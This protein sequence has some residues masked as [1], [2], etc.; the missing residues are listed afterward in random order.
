MLC[1]VK[2]RLATQDKHTKSI[3]NLYINQLK[4]CYEQME[5]EKQESLKVIYL[6]TIYTSINYLI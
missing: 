5:S 4:K 6:I 2:Y 1:E 3:E